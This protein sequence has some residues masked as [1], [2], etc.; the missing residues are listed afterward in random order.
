MER[1]LIMLYQNR[2]KNKSDGMFSIVGSIFFWFIKRL[3]ISMNPF[4]MALW[5]GVSWVKKNDNA[6][7]I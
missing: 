4:L 1:C 7:L 5:S 2:C 6:Q 3:T